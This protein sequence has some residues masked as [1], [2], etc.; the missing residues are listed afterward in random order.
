MKCILKIVY[1]VKCSNTL[2]TSVSICRSNNQLLECV[3]V[4]TF[5]HPSLHNLMVSWSIMTA[6]RLL[7]LFVVIAKSIFQVICKNVAELTILG[8]MEV[9]V[10]PDYIDT[11][12]VNYV[13]FMCKNKIC[14]SLSYNT[15]KISIFQLF[16]W[17]IFRWIIAIQG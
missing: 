1:F 5:H 3:L 2:W 7:L 6:K 9:R 17:N 10:R 14:H 4:R 13:I 8:R 12:D 11:T 16:I 15:W